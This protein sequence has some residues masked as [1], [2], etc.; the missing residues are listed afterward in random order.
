MTA[1]G[2][3][4]YEDFVHRYIPAAFGAFDASIHLAPGHNPL[5]GD[6]AGHDQVV[7]FFRRTMELSEGAAARFL[8]Q[9]LADSPSVSDLA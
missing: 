1:N 8:F 7:G 2:G 5:S 6:L 3:K 9:S 4:A